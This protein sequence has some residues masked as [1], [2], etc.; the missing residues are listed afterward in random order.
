M[1]QGSLAATPSPQ[2]MP[3]TVERRQRLL[4]GRKIH[5]SS[6]TRFTGFVPARTSQDLEKGRTLPQ[7]SSLIHR[8]VVYCHIVCAYVRATTAGKPTAGWE[9]INH[10]PRGGR[11]R[12]PNSGGA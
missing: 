4:Y 6:Y 11:L 3:P 5:F 2:T 1:P 10:G 12:S 7:I 8:A 9:R